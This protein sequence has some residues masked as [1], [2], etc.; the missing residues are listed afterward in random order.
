MEQKYKLVI[1]IISLYLSEKSEWYYNYR[2]IYVLFLLMTGFVLVNI[3]L[4]G[5][6]LF[7]EL[8]LI[9][10]LV[11]VYIALEGILGDYIYNKDI[12]ELCK[13]LSLLCIA[14]ISLT[15]LI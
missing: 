8:L 9:S 15:L 2:T 1:N 10:I 3:L 13:G 14:K 12:E 6:I 5:S 11:H 7:W 4:G